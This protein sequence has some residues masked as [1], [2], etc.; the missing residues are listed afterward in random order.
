MALKKPLETI[1][2]LIKFCGPHNERY[3][4]VIAVGIGREVEQNIRDT[5]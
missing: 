3:A 1:L 5:L 4:D 2:S